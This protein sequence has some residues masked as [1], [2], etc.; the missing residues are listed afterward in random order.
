M[1]ISLRIRDVEFF[2][3]DIIKVTHTFKE[4]EKE[5]SQAFE[6]TVI[7]IKGQGENKSF[8]IR[9]ICVD[10]VG[11]EKIFPAASPIITKI[12]VKKRGHSRRAKLYYLRKRGEKQSSIR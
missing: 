12:V 11:V 1:A 6:G 10:G 8:T 7:S 4:A 9:R 2:V 5:R 3:G